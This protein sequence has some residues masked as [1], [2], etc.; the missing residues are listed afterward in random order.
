MI[1]NTILKKR[2]QRK[3]R[4]ILFLPF[5]VLK[6]G[7][8]FF[9]HPRASIKYLS[10]KNMIKKFG[11]FD[12]DYYLEQIVDDK[13]HMHNAIRHFILHGKKNG[14]KPNKKKYSLDY[15]DYLEQKKN[16]FCVIKKSRQF[17]KNYYSNY[18]K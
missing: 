5:I 1:S 15:F 4:Y 7:A 10:T 13:L 3:S 12:F 14:Y 8:G 16:E 17:D 11:N 18:P 6:R 9:V 2:Q